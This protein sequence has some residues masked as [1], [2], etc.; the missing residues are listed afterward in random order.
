[1]KKFKKIAFVF[2][3]FLSLNSFSQD[4]KAMKDAFTNS[5]IF[6]SK[7]M[8]PEAIKTMKDIYSEKS[9][10]INARLGWLY[11]L[12][13]EYA[14]SI[15]YYQKAVALN[16][17]ATEPLWGLVLPQIALEKWADVETTYLTI[18]RFD[19]KNS[20]VNYRL[21]MIYYYKKN[22]TEAL[23]YFDVTLTLYPLDYDAIVMSAWTN[24]F[25]GKKEEAK[26]LFNRT[27]LMYQT[28]PSSLEG[29]ALCN[30]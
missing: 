8:F 22:Y 27:L 5:F 7:L 16:P 10:L 24:Y 14:T 23:K 4:T 26:V 28:D 25:L 20:L 9:Y 1:M 2:C 3:L 30:K 29:L 6:E 21:G 19:P 15:T 18:V 11:Y 13:Q 17:K 12:K